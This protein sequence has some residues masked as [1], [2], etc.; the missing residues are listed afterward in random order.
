[1]GLVARLEDGSRRLTLRFSYILSVHDALFCYIL[2]RL[3]CE[4][5]AIADLG[6]ETYLMSSSNKKKVINLSFPLFFSSPFLLFLSFS[7]PLFS[8]SSPARFSL[9]CWA[10]NWRL[11]TLRYFR[12]AT[13]SRLWITVTASVVTSIILVVVCAHCTILLASL[14]RNRTLCLSRDAGHW[15]RRTGRRGNAG[16]LAIVQERESQ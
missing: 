13:I 12:P 1:M 16:L 11:V 3:F 15:G 9:F 8:F 14:K 5:P 4:Q 7:S 6:W 10:T 2:G